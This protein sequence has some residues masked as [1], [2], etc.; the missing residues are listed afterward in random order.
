MKIEYTGHARLCLEVRGIEED[1]VKH[2][3]SSPHSLYYDISTNTLIAVGKRA[4]RQGH[5]LI[6]AFR[7]TGD[8]YRIVTVID[9]KN[10][11]RLISRRVA[12]GRR[13]HAW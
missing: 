4:K 11:K 12:S 13:I 10:A 1:E 6:I 9:A 3:L 2:V 5:W 7:R 8:T